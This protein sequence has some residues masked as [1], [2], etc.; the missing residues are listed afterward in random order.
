MPRPNILLLLTDSQQADTVAPASQCQ[1]PNVAQ[2]CREGTRFD[3]CYTASPICSP[4]R[5]T[6]MSGVLPHNHGVVRNSHV[7]E[8]HRS[9]LLDD[10]TLWSEVLADA[11]YRLGYFGK[12]HVERSG[13]LDRFGFDEHEIHGSNAYRD[14][15]TDH[16]TARGLSEWPDRSP[17][18]L[19]RSRTV[20]GEG[21]EDQ[22]LY[23]THDEPE[24]TRAH[25]TYSRGIEFIRAAADRSEPW[26]ATISTAAPH[27]PFLA[28]ASTSEQYDPGALSLPANVDDEMADRPDLY[29]RLPP[30]WADLSRAE[31]RE[32]LAHYYAYC[33]HLDEQVGRVRAALAE[34]GQLEDTLVVYA[35]DHGDLMT[36]H[37]LFA[38]GFTAFEEIYRAPLVVRWPGVGADGAVCADPVQLHDVGPTLCDVADAGPFPPEQNEVS[39]HPRADDE[40]GYETYGAQSLVPFLRGERPPGYRP[41]AYAEY[42]GDSFGLTQRVY[43]DDRSKYVFN[44]YATDEL[45][46]LEQDPGE[47]TNLAEA[48]RD[49]VRAMAE[50]MW[51][52]AADTGDATITE[53]HYWL[54]RHAPVGPRGREE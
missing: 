7:V 14:G 52:I 5:A 23:G 17:S 44:P 46:D 27:D 49:R 18:S 34:T 26:C 53:N 45:Y 48:D 4:S 10:V 1:M 32:A 24:G 47:T 28:P 43:W 12:W 51:E 37:G 21:Y 31:F 33:T 50:R 39:P 36:A 20:S 54:N 15:Y 6:L 22:L 30:V 42:E 13:E 19:Q 11:G 40:P 35:S 25:Y 29:P 38:H 16:R 3:R 8:S 41:E 2:F 9:G